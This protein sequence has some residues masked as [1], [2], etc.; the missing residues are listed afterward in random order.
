MLPSGLFY[1]LILL[2]PG[3]LYGARILALFPV[4]SQSHY[5]HAL[6]YLK[7]LASLGHEITLVSPFPPEKPVNNIYDIYVPE[8]FNSFDELLKTMTTPKNTWEFFDATN[9]FVYNIT[10]DVFNN[11]GVRR[12]ILRPGKAQFD[13]II[14]DIWKYDAF[15]GLAAYFE[16]P[17]IGLAPC[18]TDWKIDEMVGSPSPMSYLQSPSSYLYDLDTFGGRMAHFVERS[19]SWFTWHWH[20]EKKHEA[21]YKKYFPK[22]AETKPLSE[23]S[24]NIALV[25]VN[26]HFTLGPPRPYVPNV[27]E[28]GGMHIDQQPKAL[29]QE[30]EDFIQGAGE[31]GV[32]YFSL[33]TNVRTK[34]MVED[35][36]RILIEA[37]GSLPQR[38]L[39]KFDD[40][41]L[42]DIPS[43]VLVRK[44]LPQQ[45][46]L[47]HPKVKLFI[48]HG[49]MQSTIESIHYGKPMLGLPFFYDQFTNVDHIKKQGLGLALNYHDMTSDELK[50]T[51]LQL[52][53][54]K[55]F[56]V[57]ARIAGARYRDQPMK[58]LETAVWWTHYVLRHKGAPHM[59]VAG[60]KLNF[61]THHS[62]DVLGTVLL[63]IIV[64]L[65]IVLII[66]FS[67][68]KISK[69][70][71]T[72]LVVKKR[73][74]RKV[75]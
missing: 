65:A 53:T 68:C 58:P 45:D 18:G 52:L 44:W 39:W 5:Y 51:I 36:K 50:D 19:I 61:F 10:K 72:R 48:T 13:L 59:R 26:Q 67:V 41:E 75:R 56:E 54:E 63:A 42:Q 66:V 9:E 74:K 70:I 40:E 11:D 47:A 15:Y 37:F 17:I 28:V 2:F 69:N 12:E 38:I 46:I 21:L 4:P 32:I 22:I 20:Y 24:Q 25:L 49:G 30:L 23:I 73:R 1:L 62:L 6:P 71:L 8:V 33:G 7:N 57:T 29:T 31:H 27:I 60:R 14:V 64:V 3:F 55:R 34:N 16:A 43:N 35:R